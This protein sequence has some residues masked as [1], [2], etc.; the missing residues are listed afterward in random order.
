MSIPS[1]PSSKPSLMQGNIL[2][3]LQ[4]QQDM[5]EAGFVPT[6]TI[7]GS[8]VV[9]C[10]RAGQLE[11]AMALLSA[12]KA[13]HCRPSLDNWHA[14]LQACVS[15]GSR[16]RALTLL[17]RIRAAGLAPTTLTYN[18]ALR[19][20]F[21]IGSTV[22]QE[23]LDR[24]FQ[25]RDEMQEE[26]VPAD[27]VT[28]TSL[29]NL[30]G[31][32]R[33]P[34]R[35]LALIQAMEEQGIAPDQA[36]LTAIIQACG[37]SRPHDALHF[38]ERLEGG[39]EAQG[40]GE[41]AYR[42]AASICRQM[43]WLER[44]LAVMRAA[45]AAGF[46]P[47]NRHFREMLMACAE[48]AM[49]ESG[50]VRS[51]QVAEAL[52]LLDW[53]SV[54][55][56]HGYK[57]VEGRVA[58]LCVLAAIQERFRR[59][60]DISD[61]IIVTGQGR[62]SAQD[63]PVLRD[64]IRHLLNQELHL[65]TSHYGGRPASLPPQGRPRSKAEATPPFPD[66][67]VPSLPT[68]PEAR[69][70]QQPHIPNPAGSLHHEHGGQQLP[71]PPRRATGPQNATTSPKG[72]GS[73]RTDA[74]YSDNTGHGDAPDVSQGG[75]RRRLL[76][77]RQSPG[78][79]GAGEVGGGGTGNMDASGG[80]DGAASAREGVVRPAE[81]ATIRGNSA[82]TVKQGGGAGPSKGRGWRRERG[83]RDEKDGKLSM[84]RGRLHVSRAD[85]L[86]WLANKQS[87]MGVPSTPQQE[88]A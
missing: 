68:L 64:A 31:H 83:R 74:G 30:C 43:G 54:V 1:T 4:V 45:R 33:A 66:N 58:V 35:A 50:S 80:G 12:M 22:P 16:E 49:R 5:E 7:W 87:R 86:R 72:K 13:G 77:E 6:P 24:A 69:G 56:L 48:A 61:L 46:P 60:E 65:P 3:V 52:G 19:A 29:I 23:V 8:L 57:A 27:I 82:R 42:E 18:L 34:D 9:A 62:H 59:G 14:L 32:A 76:A 73:G 41:Q 15:C 63:G 37:T 75:Q 38:F 55:D 21:T 11:C 2:R 71:S 81:S 84:N 17:P 79:S 10:G 25:L 36:C 26:G 67:Q 47:S 88:G 20:C 40:P 78:R 85:L 39:E 51:S 53:E 28:Y 44:G 70:Q